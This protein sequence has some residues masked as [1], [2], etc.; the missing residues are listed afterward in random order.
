MLLL[1][2]EFKL[3]YSKLYSNLKVVHELLLEVLKF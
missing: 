2:A 3:L 1:F